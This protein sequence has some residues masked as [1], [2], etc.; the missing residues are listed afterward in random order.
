[1]LGLRLPIVPSWVPPGLTLGLALTSPRDV[2]VRAELPLPETPQFP[3]L[4]SRAQALDLGLALGA[5]F[6]QSWFV[7]IGLR[8]LAGLSGDVEVATEDDAGGVEDEL[9]LD[10]APVLG[11]IFRPSSR[12]SF[13]VVYR[14]A[15][16]APFE[17]ELRDEGLPGITLPPLQIDGT[18]HYDPAELGVEWAHGFGAT[19]AAL[20]LVYQRWSAFEGWLGRTVDCP[21]SEPDCGALP[22][23][24]VALSNIIS[25]RFGVSHLLDWGSVEL[26][27]RA[28]YAY[29]ASPLPEQI[30]S[31]NRW[32][33]ARS[34]ITAGWSVELDA[35]ALGLAYQLHV[36]H[37]RNHR[38]RDS[39]ADPALADVSVSGNVQFVGL[40]LELRY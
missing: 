3:L 25:P 26:T 29:E 9:T 30:G 2:I 11:V 10:L 27:L 14:G 36:L 17:V 16:A 38:K 24:V 1:V 33:N 13:G 12:D 6:T 40:N 8:G 32:D 22:K 18:A 39:T 31:A 35:V 15:L 7:G 19:R 5:R 20:G 34:V 23:E 28:G 37:E 21:D 4:S